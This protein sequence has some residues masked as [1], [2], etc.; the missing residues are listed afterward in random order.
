MNR[1]GAEP[2]DDGT[3]RFNLWAPD[4]DAVA[5]EI[6]DEADRKSVV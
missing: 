6:D 3:T 2:C 4:A 5:I 1:W